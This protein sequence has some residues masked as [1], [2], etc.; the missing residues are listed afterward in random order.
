MGGN[1]QPQF[2][3]NGNITPVA[4]TAAN[5]S[6][7]GGGTIATD[8][9]LAF[10]ADATNG[11]YVEYVRLMP[12]SSAAA[13]ATNATTARIFL[14]TKTSGATS[15][16]NTFL[17]A[18][19]SLPSVTADSTTVG[20]APIDVPIGFRLPAGN[21]LLVTNHIAPAANTAWVATAVGGDY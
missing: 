5:T 1:A 16:A 19:V 18:E 4:V 17:I 9:F 10:T 13:T 11:S 6:S 15:S 14:S 8:I 3:R 2:T 21:T 20:V 7:Q 12:T